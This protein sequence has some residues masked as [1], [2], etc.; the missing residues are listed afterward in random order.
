M[1]NIKSQYLKSEILKFFSLYKLMKIIKY[2]KK[3][4]DLLKYKEVFDCYFL[5]ENLSQDEKSGYIINYEKFLLQ[6]YNELTEE[7]IKKIVLNSLKKHSQNEKNYIVINL[8][9]PL[10]ND[11]LDNKN[12]IKNITLSFEGEKGLDKIYNIKNKNIRRLNFYCLD[13]V[14]NLLY[15][16][17]DIINIISQNI[18][19]IDSVKEI[20]IEFPLDANFLDLEKFKI[21][22]KKLVNNSLNEEFKNFFN[23]N[24]DIFIINDLQ[25]YDI[26]SLYFLYKLLN[27]KNLEKLIIKIQDFDNLI[28]FLSRIDFSP[29]KNLKEISFELYGDFD[30]E[31]INK[32]FQLC[33]YITSLNIDKICDFTIFPKLKRLNL[34]LQKNLPFGS[35]DDLKFNCNNIK[36]LIFSENIEANALIKFVDKLKNLEELSC[37]FVYYG[38]VLQFEELINK[39]NSNLG[40][41]LKKF[42]L[43]GT[44]DKT[45]LIAKLNLPNLTHLYCPINF[46]ELSKKNIFKNLPKLESIVLLNDLSYLNGFYSELFPNNNENIKELFLPEIPFKI[47]ELK[48]ILSYPNITNLTLYF[49]HF[50]DEYYE[51]FINNYNYTKMEEIKIILYNNFSKEEKKKVEDMAKKYYIRIKDIISKKSKFLNKFEFLKSQNYMPL[52]E[53]EEEIKD[54]YSRF[55][56]LVEPS[57]FYL[58]KP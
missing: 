51:V 21:M 9:E 56:Y 20:S 24:K 31:L 10:S 48:K 18:D 6:K 52:Y 5:C 26:Y 3:F 55:K 14:D 23:K 8:S 57:L 36:E 44:R 47:E 11:I 58:F 50:N 7:D 45:Y 1:L 37:V 53:N 33:P 29:L 40:N 17:N 28:K 54:L 19:I 25:N 15:F 43:E 4:I 12:E 46:N 41:T 38:T 32:N 49:V 2:S 30:I 13:N 27:F 42:H 16:Y 39:L 35:L 22:E 34:V